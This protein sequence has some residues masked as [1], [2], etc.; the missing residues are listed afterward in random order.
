MGEHEGGGGGA[1]CHSGVR[2]AED[3]VTPQI[4]TATSNGALA[5]VCRLLVAAEHRYADAS[6]SS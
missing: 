1:G 5:D 4:Q 3:H 2:D 6:S